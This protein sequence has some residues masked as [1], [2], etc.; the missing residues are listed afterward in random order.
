[1]I[2]MNCD[3]VAAQEVGSGENKWPARNAA[4]ADAAPDELPQPC[5]CRWVC[6]QRGISAGADE[7]VV[8]SLAIANSKIG[9]NGD[10]IGGARRLA[11]D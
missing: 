10:A 7:D 2:P 4:D 6:E 3:P 11:I 9:L 8:K 1:M 5:K